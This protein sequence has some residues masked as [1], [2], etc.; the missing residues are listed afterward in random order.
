MGS[1]S[2]ECDMKL[3]DA[4]VKDYQHNGYLVVERL[5]SDEEVGQLRLRTEE[6]AA[7][8]IAYPEAGHGRIFRRVKSDIKDDISSTGNR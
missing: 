6:I 1:P 5:C 4:D 3:N 2:Y 7:G 8:R